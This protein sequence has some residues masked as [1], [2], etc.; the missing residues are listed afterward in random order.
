VEA[1]FIL[2]YGAEV[3][4]LFADVPL[5]RHGSHSCLAIVD[6]AICIFAHQAFRCHAGAGSGGEYG[7]VA[8]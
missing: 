6:G 7:G 2:R 1:E 5:H 8:R 4:H 3:A